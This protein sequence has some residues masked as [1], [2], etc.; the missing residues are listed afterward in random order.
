M[1]TAGYRH[2]VGRPPQEPAHKL[3]K[4]RAEIRWLDR[5]V[6]GKSAEVFD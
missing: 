5:Y 6:L 4:V 1:L 3:T 2:L